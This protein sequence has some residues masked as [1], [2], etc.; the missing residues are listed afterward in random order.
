MGNNRPMRGWVLIV[1]RWSLAALVLGAT[2]F[3]QNLPPATR[4]WSVG[5]LTKSEPV[6]GFAFGSGGATVMAHSWLT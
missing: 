2:A 4:L 5:P 1:K 6:M 3:A